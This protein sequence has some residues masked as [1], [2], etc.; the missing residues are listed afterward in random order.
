MAAKPNPFF[1]D[2]YNV[3]TLRTFDQ[4]KIGSA[5]IITNPGF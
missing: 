3:S 1:Y 2:K 4:S 5:L